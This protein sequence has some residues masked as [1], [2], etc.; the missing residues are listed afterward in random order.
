MGLDSTNKGATLEPQKNLNNAVLASLAG[1]SS[2]VKVTSAPLFPSVTDGCTQ[3]L[4]PAS[5][6]SLSL[7]TVTVAVPPVLVTWIVSD[8]NDIEDTPATSAVGSLSSSEQLHKARTADNI[9]AKYLNCFIFYLLEV[10]IN[11]TH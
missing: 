3:S 1:L 10:V 2:M 11:L 4:T 7:V 8:D 5:R 9:I 6:Q